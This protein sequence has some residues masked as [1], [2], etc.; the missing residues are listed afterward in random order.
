MNSWW[1]NTNPLLNQTHE[2]GAVATHAFFK[3]VPGWGGCNGIFGLGW[4][5]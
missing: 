3:K 2:R 1:V 5:A 4:V